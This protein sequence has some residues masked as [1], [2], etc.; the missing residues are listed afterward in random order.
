MQGACFYWCNCWPPRSPNVTTCPHRGLFFTFVCKA[1]QGL[2]LD[3]YTYHACSLLALQ[4]C[5][6]RPEIRIEDCGPTTVL[7]TKIPGPGARG[8]LTKDRKK[9][10]KDRGW[11]SRT[12]WSRTGTK[13]NFMCKYVLNVKVILYQNTVH[14][15][16]FTMNWSMRILFRI[17][18]LHKF[19]ETTK[20]NSVMLLC[21]LDQKF[22][23]P[24]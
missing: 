12:G 17:S 2:V 23:Y 20:Y 21:S 6:W 10:T 3:K 5:W 15:Q 22:W 14:W 1:F 24:W 18:S 4:A 16:V 11:T 7:E 19:S 9:K 13:L 8:N